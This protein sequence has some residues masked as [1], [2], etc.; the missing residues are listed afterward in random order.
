MN[1]DKVVFCFHRNIHGFVCL[2]LP[3]WHFDYVLQPKYTNYYF[4]EPN[5][6]NVP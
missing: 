5:K 3:P 4:T 1:A 2:L 6:N